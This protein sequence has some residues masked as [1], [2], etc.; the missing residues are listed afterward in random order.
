[1]TRLLVVLGIVAAAS[2]ARAGSIDCERL[3]PLLRDR[4]MGNHKR[5]ALL[6]QNEQPE[7]SCTPPT[8]AP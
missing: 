1:M 6:P 5:Q 4:G 8:W 3:L 7:R 2:I